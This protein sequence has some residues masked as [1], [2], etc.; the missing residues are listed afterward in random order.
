MRNKGFEY[1]LTTRNFVGDFKWTSN[2]T[3]SY[4]R[5]RV[6]DI[7]K[8]KRPI[9]SNDGYT[10]ENRP[11]AGIWGGSFLG[12]YRD[13]EDVKTSPIVNANN[14]NWRFRSAPGTAKLAD[15]NGDGIIDAS[16]NTVIGSA[17]PD[18]IWGMNH[19]FEYKGF[20]MS[21]QVNGTHGG[22]VS[23]RQMEGIFGR[24]AGNANTTRDY[25]NNYW[26]PDRPDAKYIAPSRKSYDGT[27]TSG[28]LLYKGTFVN[29]QNVVLGYTFPS[30]VLEKVKL[31]RLRVYA[32]IINAL[33]IT[34]FPGYN[35]EANFQGDS[36]LSQGINRD[37]YPMSRSISFG[38][39]LTF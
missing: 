32:S 13:W 8:D 11:I 30:S 39:N 9:L 6:L 4:Y 34:K 24:G 37:S 28:S 3:L 27:N 16:D 18:F 21:V 36:A 26:T 33:Y 31:S 7:G 35:P 17:I 38:V 20:D 10:T 12:P 23:M 1:A 22:D 14:S 15:V 25:Y 5:N 2:F 29:I 19:S